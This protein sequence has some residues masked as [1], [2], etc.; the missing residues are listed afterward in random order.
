MK[1]CYLTTFTYPSAFANRLQVLKMSEAFSGFCDFTLVVGGVTGDV[2]TIFEDNSVRRPCILRSLGVS[3]GRLRMVRAVWALLNIIRTCPSD[4][5]FYMREPLP[6]FM[7]SFLSSQ[8]RNIF[9]FEAHSFARYPAFIYRRVFSCARGIV[10]TSE[11]KAIVFR[12]SFGVPDGKLLVRGNGFDAGF[13]THMLSREEARSSLG[14]PLEK[15]IVVMIGKPTEERDIGTFLA[16][17]EELPDVLFLS[18]GGLPHEI[19]RLQAS[20]GFGRVRFVERVRPEE[21]AAYYAASDVVAV[22]LSTAFLEIAEFASPL[23]AREALAT[24][25]PVIF[26][27][28]PALRDVADG[29]L[30]TFV[31]PDDAEKL[32]GGVRAIFSDYGNHAAKAANARGIFLKQSWQTR[33]ED[34]VGFM[35]NMSS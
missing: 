26:S 24:G 14:L 17:A 31:E 19:K 6:A 16:A 34:I 11:K 21:V 27:D 10:A 32:A 33:A 20:K 5:V 30:V 28:V 15:R 22:L 8:F 4:T 7:I 2:K 1:L 23:K 35:K 25:V 13:F 9:F 18:V 12:N 29:S 3:R